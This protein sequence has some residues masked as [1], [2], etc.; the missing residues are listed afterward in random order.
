[1]SKRTK[2]KRK[3]KSITL[4]SLFYWPSHHFTHIYQFIHWFRCKERKHHEGRDR[5]AKLIP[6]DYLSEIRLFDNGI[7][8]RNFTQNLTLSRLH[9]D[10]THSHN[11]HKFIWYS[12]F[13]YSTSLNKSYLS[14]NI[15]VIHNILCMFRK[16]IQ[17]KKITKN[18]RLRL[19]RD[20]L[21]IQIQ[22][23]IYSKY[24]CIKKRQ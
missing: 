24:L 13:S 17:P 15:L 19:H 18:A 9:I 6:I 20:K 12:A 8:Q 14:I 3:K 10:K 11:K 7:F 21:I 4:R 23:R 22:N 5:Y 1:M 16:K 2:A